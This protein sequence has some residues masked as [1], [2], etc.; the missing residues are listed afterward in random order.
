MRMVMLNGW[1]D[2]ASSRSLAAVG[3]NV[4]TAEA[5]GS[6]MLLGLSS[7]GSSKEEG[8]GTSRGH[9]DEFVKGEAFATSLG[10]T[11]TGSFGEAEGGNVKLWHFSD[12]L[13]IGD[14]SDNNCGSVSL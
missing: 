12:T 2:R 9:Q 4:G 1:K 10:D 6:E 13:I 7:G 14:G 11:G 8:V 5:G 3:L